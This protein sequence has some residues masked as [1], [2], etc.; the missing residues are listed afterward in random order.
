MSI[1]NNSFNYIKHS[2]KYEKW[3]KLQ[4]DTEKKPQFDSRGPQAT[5]SEHILIHWRPWKYTYLIR[6]SRIFSLLKWLKEKIKTLQ[7]F[8]ITRTLNTWKQHHNNKSLGTD[9]FPVSSVKLCEKTIPS[10]YFG[11]AGKKR[12]ASISPHMNTAFMSVLLR[13]NKNPEVATEE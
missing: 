11:T 6:N 3:N 13:P 10:L 1:C 7:N 4:C 9:G 8:I 5:L 2:N 12:S